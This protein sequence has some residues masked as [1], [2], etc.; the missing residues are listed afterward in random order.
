MENKFFFEALDR[1]PRHILRVK[2]ENNSD[3]PL[4]GLTVVVGGDFHQILPV[5]PKG[6]H[7]D[8]I[9]ALLNSSCGHF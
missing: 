9:D 1:T 6:T 7:A 5:L 2:Y 4:G 8:I 3:K